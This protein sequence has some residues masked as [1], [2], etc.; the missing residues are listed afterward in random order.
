MLKP[1]VVRDDPSEPDVARA[2]CA[3]PMGVV[4]SPPDCPKGTRNAPATFQRLM[5]MVLSGVK[6]CEAYLDDCNHCVILP[7]VLSMKRHYRRF[8]AAWKKPI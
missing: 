8:L 6:N 1:Y 5:N 3:A 4:V 2:I 7:P